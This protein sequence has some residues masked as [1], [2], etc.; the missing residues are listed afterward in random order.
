[1]EFKDYY[2]IL[3]VDKKASV[4]EIK[5][6]YRKLAMKYHP[7]RNPD[8]KSA[9]EKFK[10]IS[11]AHEVLSDPEKRKRYDQLG[12]N[13]KQYQTGGQDFGDIFSQFGRGGGRQYRTSGNFEDMF[14]NMSGFS[15]F[16]ESF[17]GGGA[18]G[19]DRFSSHRTAKGADYEAELYIMLEEAYSGTTKEISIEG[20]KLR[21][22]INPGTKDGKRLRLSKQGAVS[23]SGGEKGDLY[24]T[25][26]I[27]KH[28][29]YE[30]DGTN[31]IYDLSIDLYS[32]VLG[33]KKKF[34]T[35][36]GK[37]I[38]LTIPPGTDS[39]Q[40]FRIQ[41]MGFPLEENSNRSGD[42]IIRIKVELPKNLSSEEKK[43]FKTLSEIRK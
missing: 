31:L 9:E 24:L 33:A 35:L 30:F 1:M 39:G 41:G 4:D 42:L 18:F 32:A 26:K 8:D 29:F 15:D 43:L 40:L 10:E 14:G 36:S 28:P 11:E 13:W 37:N 7:D 38:N 20:K 2:K 16:F 21:L 22:K 17:F 19:G 25:I 12:S 34:K 3:G 23:Q 27:Q 5:K 6:A